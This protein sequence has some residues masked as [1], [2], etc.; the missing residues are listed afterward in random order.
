MI[1]YSPALTNNEQNC[2][3][4][5]ETSKSINQSIIYLYQAKAEP[6][7]RLDRQERKILNNKQ[8]ISK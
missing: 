3:C 6:L 1:T 8:I 4:L 2:I 7:K 5:R